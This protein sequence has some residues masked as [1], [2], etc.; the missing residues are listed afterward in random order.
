MGWLT[1]TARLRL[2][3]AGMAA[4]E[5]AFLV[6]RARPYGAAAHA[7]LALTLALTVTAAGAVAFAPWQPGDR[8]LAWLTHA[9]ASRPRAVAVLLLATLV[10]GGLGVVTQQ[11]FSWDE[12]AVLQTA[13]LVASEGVHGLFAHYN[14]NA[15]LGPQHP[16]LVP[17]LYGAVSYAFGVHLKLLRVVNLLFGCGT[18]VLAFLV[19]ERLY[20]RRRAL[21]AALL[22]LASPLFVRIA[23]AATNDMPLMF[24]FVAALL[25]ALHLERSERDGV[26]VLLGTVIGLGL[27]VKY[28]MLLVFPVLVALAW[29]LG[30]LPLARRHAPV[31]LAVAL[32]FLLVWLDQAY[33]IGV[34][35]A[36]QRRLGHL[37]GVATRNPRWAY[38]AIVSKA[39]AALGVYLV[40]WVICGALA[41]LWRRTLEEAFALWWIV[42]VFVP[43]L[44]TLPDNRYFLPA[45]PAL[46]VLGASALLARPRV[47]GRA[48]LLAWLL[49]AVSLLFY[50][51]IDLAQKAF[52]FH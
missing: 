51:R 25:V 18:V 3:L 35:G 16:P 12:R 20:D 15:W 34:L 49:C 6:V 19:L 48:L 38:D 47:A 42:L 5:V 52:L 24:L 2:Q 14:E 22:L 28:T 4:L 13:E 27:L 21:V 7:L 11:V 29:Q 32:A 9:A 40:P 44:L 45:Y 8:L 10:V 37:A 31:V 26:A 50:A 36:Q 1:E 17:L 33:A 39:P 23:S 30:R 46:V 43:L 41:A